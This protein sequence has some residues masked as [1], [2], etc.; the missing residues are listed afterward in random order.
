M[1]ILQIF[2]TAGSN[3]DNQWEPVNSNVPANLSSVVVSNLLPSRYYRFQLTAVNKLGESPPSDAAPS[4]AIKMPAQ[5]K[6]FVFVFFVRIVY[7]VSF[8]CLS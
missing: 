3:I 2:F 5:R 6:F 8:I 7:D 1:Y 4:G